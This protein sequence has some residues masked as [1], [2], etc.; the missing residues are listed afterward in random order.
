MRKLSKPELTLIGSALLTMSAFAFAPGLLRNVPS[1]GAMLD[2]IQ[3]GMDAPHPPLGAPHFAI[4]PP[5]PDYTAP[6]EPTAKQE[7]GAPEHHG[8]DS[9]TVF[10]DAEPNGGPSPVFGHWGQFRLSGGGSS[11]FDHPAIAA[12]ISAASPQNRGD[13]QGAA[14]EGATNSAT[15]GTAD[16]G[17]DESG[18][19]PGGD[20]S[21]K[22]PDTPPGQTELAQLTPPAP[23]DL[24]NPLNGGDQPG[25]EQPAAQVPEPSSLALLIAGLAGLVLCRRRA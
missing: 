22:K 23:N 2:R 10:T 18:Q 4:A 17:K 13:E 6:A 19:Q 1:I 12:R 14:G 8:G 20:T 21:D 15:S 9:Y 5:E 3:P 16:K 7:L 24:H 25:G 11:R